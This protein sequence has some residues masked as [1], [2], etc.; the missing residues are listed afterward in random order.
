MYKLLAI[1]YV[2]NQPLKE[3]IKYLKEMIDQLIEVV[4]KK[5]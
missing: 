2:E 4:E 1:G 5:G 3:E